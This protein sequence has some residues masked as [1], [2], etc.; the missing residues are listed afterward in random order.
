MCPRPNLPRGCTHG[1][2]DDSRG[3]RRV[4]WTLGAAQDS[5]V[6]ARKI[7][8]E[9]ELASLDPGKDGPDGCPSLSGHPLTMRR[10]TV[11]LS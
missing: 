11:V 7:K 6:K 10:G 1:S 9:L 8:E 2:F 5:L 3:S 4:S